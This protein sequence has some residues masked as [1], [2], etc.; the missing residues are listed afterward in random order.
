MEVHRRIIPWFVLLITIFLVVSQ[1]GRATTMTFDTVP[2]VNTSDTFWFHLQDLST[3][4]QSTTVQSVP[5]NFANVEKS[6]TVSLDDRADWQIPSIQADFRFNGSP[7][8]IPT[9]QLPAIANDLSNNP[10]IA[11]LQTFWTNPAASGWTLDYLSAWGGAQTV[12][13]P[14]N[15]YTFNN[16]PKLVSAPTKIPTA[17]LVFDTPASNNPYIGGGGGFNIFDDAPEP[18]SLILTGAGLGALA[19]AA[20]RRKR[21]QTVTTL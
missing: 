16:D 12:N 5:S 15:Q 19:L 4:I 6:L 1:P 14:T 11:A 17:F 2:W 13:I 10:S 20:A 8:N 21:R 3:T 7:A 9:P 18:A